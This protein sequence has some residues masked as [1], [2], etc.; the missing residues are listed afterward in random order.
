[1]GQYDVVVTA[2]GPIRQFDD[3]GERIGTVAD[4][5]FVTTIQNIVQA[6]KDL[7]LTD[8]TRLI[9]VGGTGSLFLPNGEKVEDQSW[10]PATV[11]GEAQQ[12]T[13]SLSYLLT[14]E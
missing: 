7:S 12:H 14:E 4:K 5:K 9:V 8:K 11:L 10:F 1:M 2:H 13:E 3:K 6:L